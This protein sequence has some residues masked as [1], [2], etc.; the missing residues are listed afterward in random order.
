MAELVPVTDELLARAR[1]DR[2]LRQA[3]VSEH[4]TRLMQAMGK[5]KKWAHNDAKVTRQVQEGARLAVRLTE[6]LHGLGDQAERS[7]A[8]PRSGSLPAAAM[9]QADALHSRSKPL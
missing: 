6:I 2:A 3:L 7:P 8:A 5:A 1:T 9:T 4:L